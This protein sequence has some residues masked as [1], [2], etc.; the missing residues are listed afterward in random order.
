MKLIRWAVLFLALYNNVSS[1]SAF[2][3]GKF[4]NPVSDICWRCLFPMSLGNR[5]VAKGIL[6]D[7]PNIGSLVCHCSGVKGLPVGINIGFWEP[8]AIIEVVRHPFCLTSLNGLSVEGVHHLRGKIGTASN[9][10]G[11]KSSAFYHVHWYHFPVLS[12]M[13]VLSHGQCIEEGLWD[14]GYMSEFDLAWNSDEWRNVLNPESMLY[15]LPQSQA[16]CTVDA[17]QSATSIPNDHLFWCAG[18]H[19]NLYPLTGAISHWVSGPQA[20]L[21]LSERVIMKLHQQMRL[22]DSSETDPNHCS[23]IFRPIMP[24]SH[25][26]LQM[27]YPVA[28]KREFACSPTGRSS[29]M[30]ESLHQFPNQGEDFTYLVWRKRNCCYRR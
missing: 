20:S 9:A 11:N 26:R 21:L 12:M 10:H 2:C 3:H 13:D 14:L 18:A 16:L 8:I 4:V 6:P 19:G 5:Q 28:E 15:A 17:I 27:L 29:V 25:Y 24:K 30:W 22:S 7:T 1:A 23:S